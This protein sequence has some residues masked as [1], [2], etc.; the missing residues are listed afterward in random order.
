MRKFIL[1]ALMMIATQ[2]GAQNKEAEAVLKAYEKS[3]A[4][5][6]GKKAQDASSWVRFGKNIIAVYDQPAKNLLTGLSSLEVKVVLKDQRST[7]SESRVI[8]GE[9]YD[10]VL[11]NDKELFYN[12]T[13]SLAFWRITKH[14]L[15]Q[16]LLGE[17]F[18]AYQKGYELDAK[19]SQKRDLAEGLSNLQNRYISEAMTA[20]SLGE[21]SLSS[22]N[23]GYS[24]R[25][26]EHPIINNIDTV[27]VFYTGLTAFNA[28]EFERAIQYI[29]R[30]IDMGYA[31]DGA[32]YSFLAESYK[33]LD[34]ADKMESVLAE[35]F[36]K[37][38]SNQGILISLINMFIDNDE[39]PAKVMEYIHK[40]QENE[41]TNESLHYAEG[42]V[43]R[44]LNDFDKAIACYKQS[45]EINPNYFYGYYSLGSMFYDAAVEAQNKA[46][47]ELD[48]KKYVAL[49]DEMDALL[50]KAI[51]PF[52]KSV[53]FCD[54]PEILG[55][56]N[57]YLRNIYYR[58][59]GK[60]EETY[61][62]LYEKYRDLVEGK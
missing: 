36:T 16:D 18:D 44:K 60:D 33:S 52:E 45:V 19:G 34:Q 9:E 38:P 59:Q 8:D 42:N 61:K 7:G 11:Y 50:V 14:L 46:S 55:D 39:D 17:A 57:L 49:L 2:L 1:C 31:Q 13:G 26:A 15:P 29:Q 54:I 53:I 20:Y 40:A 5:V 62:P 41:P 47:E 4:D 43:W 35:G 24:I 28:K 23:F 6:T 48:D 3:K 32:A 25:C 10:V 22:Q 58:L 51:D 21:F 30:A 37:Y 27:V 56:I 12:E